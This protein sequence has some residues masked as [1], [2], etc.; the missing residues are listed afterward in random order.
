[1]SLI[2]LLV[3][4]AAGLIAGH[5]LTLVPL[6]RARAALN[7][8]TDDANHD[9]LTGLPNRRA[10]LA[11]LADARHHGEPVT[12][13]MLDLDHFKT[14]NDQYGHDAGD[15]LLLEVADRLA[16]QPAPVRLA[17]RLHGDEYVLVIDGNADQGV[18]A[19]YAA[20]DAIS[21][22]PALVTESSAVTVTAS[23][24]VSASRLGATDRQLLHEADLAMYDAKHS[25]AGVHLHTPGTAGPRVPHRPARRIRDRRH[26]PD[27]THN[28]AHDDSP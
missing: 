25:R 3:A 27:H 18:S 28:D 9:D 8:A 12:V 14:I 11:H 23:V 20:L 10:L 17:A 15:Q 7:A 22:A 16:E 19:A 13:A 26:R 1:M 4:I 24:G 5:A 2:P 6:R 21:D